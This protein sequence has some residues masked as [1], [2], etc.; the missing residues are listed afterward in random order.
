MIEKV[1][2][3]GCNVIEIP[4]HKQFKCSS[5]K[6]IQILFT[7]LSSQLLTFSE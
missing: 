2:K 4:Q 1:V 6:L 5:Q 7:K 3:I